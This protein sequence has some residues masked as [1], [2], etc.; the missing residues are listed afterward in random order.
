[1]MMPTYSVVLIA[2]MLAIVVGRIGTLLRQG[3]EYER[4]IKR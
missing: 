3:Y 4:Q 2:I 1:M